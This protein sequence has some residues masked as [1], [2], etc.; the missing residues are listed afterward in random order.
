[1]NVKEG[2]VYTTVAGLI[3][4]AGA[5]QAQPNERPVFK[6]KKKAT[7]EAEETLVKKVTPVTAKKD[8]KTVANPMVTIDGLKTLADSGMAAAQKMYDIVKNEYNHRNGLMLYADPMF[9][10]SVID[11]RLCDN[12]NYQPDRLGEFEKVREL[13]DNGTITY[14]SEVNA[15]KQCRS[16][17]KSA[18]RSKRSKSRVKI[19]PPCSVHVEQMDLDTTVATLTANG[20]NV[21]RFSEGN[22][23]ETIMSNVSA[24]YQAFSTDEKTKDS[25]FGQGKKLLGQEYLDALVS[26]YNAFG[27]NHQANDAGQ[28][29]KFHAALQIVYQD[30]ANFM[31]YQKGAVV[32]Q[33]AKEGQVGYDAKQTNAFRSE[34]AMK[35]LVEGGDVAIAFS[36]DVYN[37]FCWL[38]DA[39]SQNSGN[40][41]EGT[42]KTEGNEKA[43]G[44][45][46]NK[47]EQNSQENRTTNDDSVTVAPKGFVEQQMNKLLDQR[48]LFGAGYSLIVDEDHSEGKGYG[49]AHGAQLTYLFVGKSGF[50]IGGSFNYHNANYQWNKESDTAEENPLYPGFTGEG[51]KTTMRDTNIFGLGLN[52]GYMV[53][54]RAIAFLASAALMYETGEL[55]TTKLENILGP[56]GESVSGNRES[57]SKDVSQLYGAF[58]LNVPIRLAQGDGNSSLYLMPSAEVRTPFDSKDVDFRGTVN[59]LYCAI[60][61]QQQ[62][63]TNDN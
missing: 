28:A 16:D 9:G 44:T 24:F 5:V 58:G 59:L 41:Q 10:F 3:L 13:V 61:K 32:A 60:M 18:K 37:K 54:S 33:T 63:Q 31:R 25:F 57:I 48:H 55:E 26:A 52:M 14:T 34:K 27:E 56:D 49:L 53:D 23:F 21:V 45:Q 1:M 17:A 8:E 19:V 38:V 15:L 12:K 6:S 36:N 47:G 62:T 22:D 7:E 20:A 2:I 29:S 11:T 42:Q 51:T 46:D 39:V 40:V 30:M 4:S 35:S 50:V 43:E